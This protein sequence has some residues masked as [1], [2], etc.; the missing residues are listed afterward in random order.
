MNAGL[1]FFF[2]LLLLGAVAGCVYLGMEVDRANEQLAETS[3]LLSKAE[4][5]AEEAIQ[6]AAVI[7]RTNQELVARNEHN[8]MSLSQ[9]QS[10]L[11]QTQK[12]MQIREEQIADFQ[13]KLAKL[14][15]QYI[16]MERTYAQT[17]QENAIL[18]EVSTQ[19]IQ[20]IDALTQQVA[21]LEFQR[22]ALGKALASPNLKTVEMT[23]SQETTPIKSPIASMESWLWV[24]LVIGSVVDG[25]GIGAWTGMNFYRR[26]QTRAVISQP[27]NWINFSEPK[28]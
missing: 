7:D 13:N 3:L 8:Q 25:L 5:R 21:D 22:P 16:E 20:K 6:R 11:D 27:S 1:A 17:Q 10:K 2:I 23:V 28:L 18:K 19:Q 12:N 4:G 9:V 24:A 26:W 15:H 14:T